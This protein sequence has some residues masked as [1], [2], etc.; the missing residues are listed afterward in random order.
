MLG[1]TLTITLV[2]IVG[3]WATVVMMP[4]VQAELKGSQ[5]ATQLPCTSKMVGRVGLYGNSR[6]PHGFAP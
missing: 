3:M 2:I 5:S 4:A 6:W 1:L